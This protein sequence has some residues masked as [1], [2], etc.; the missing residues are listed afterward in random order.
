[1][2]FIRASND[3]CV[4]SES[5]LENSANAVINLSRLAH[6]LCAC[7]KQ[8]MLL[9]SCSA[10]RVVIYAPHEQFNHSTPRHWLPFLEK[11]LFLHVE[12]ADPFRL[13]SLLLFFLDRLN[14]LKHHSYITVMNIT[15]LNDQPFQTH[16]L[17]VHM[18][19][20]L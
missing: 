15:L 8:D 7:V 18:N 3:V 17:R 1:M 19:F 2:K 5:R 16:L 20:R 11:L 14:Y 9:F 4:C 12:F 13:Y 6:W 10:S